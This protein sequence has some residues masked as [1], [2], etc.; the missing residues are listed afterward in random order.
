MLLSALAGCYRPVAPRG[1]TSCAS[2]RSADGALNRAREVRHL[3][4]LA[5]P[6]DS[7]ENT[8][9]IPNLERY[10]EQHPEV[11]VQAVAWAYKRNDQGKDSPELQVPENAVKNVASRAFR[12]LE[13]M[14]R[15]PGHD[16]P[17]FDKDRLPKWTAAVRESCA[18]LSRPEICDV[19]LGKLLSN[20]PVGADGVWPSEPVRQV[21]EEIQSEDMMRGAHTGVYNSRGVHWRGEG[22]DQERGLAAQYRKW[23]EALQFSHPFVSSHLLMNLAKTYEHEAN[24]EDTEAGIRRRLR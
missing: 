8:Y 16:A 22:G 23:G 24:R 20:A 14:S 2:G 10:I 1:S 7:R 21:M 18:E 9:G 12:L 15:I 4:A 6:W 3:E 19:C 17:E 5:R 13:G 11:F